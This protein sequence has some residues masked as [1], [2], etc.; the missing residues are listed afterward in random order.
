MLPPMAPSS[1]SSSR[2]PF[3]PFVIEGTPTP[4]AGGHTVCC[5]LA[6]EAGVFAAHFPGRPIV[7]GVFLLKLAVMA[8]NAVRQSE[9]PAT[10]AFD[11]VEVKNA[12]FLS[13]VEPTTV[14]EVVVEITHKPTVGQAQKIKADIVGGQ[15][16]YA[17]FV[18]VVAPT[19]DSGET[20]VPPDAPQLAEVCGL[21]PTYN[22]AATLAGVV[23]GVRARLDHVIVVDDGSDDT[24]DEILAEVCGADQAEQ[25]RRGFTVL[26]HPHNRG[27]GAALATGLGYARAEGYRYAVTVD[28]DG[29]H[30]PSDIPLLL[31]PL[32]THPDA[33]VLGSR[34]SLSHP[35]KS[36]GS[37]FANRFSNFWFAVQTF[38]RLPDT[39]CGLRVYPL[40]R[41][42]SRLRLTS[43]YEAELTLLVFP[44]WRGT[45]VVPVTVDVCYP[46][47]AERVSHFRPVRDFARISLLNTCLCFLAV[48]WG[49]PR[50]AWHALRRRRGS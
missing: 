29:Q 20:A 13:V 22:N 48:V 49:W 2:P 4:V 28:A 7:P 39:Q 9:A 25:R 47:A 46:P 26:T 41:L 24:T 15:T 37:T 3:F 45:E 8:F 50:L 33:L 43:G 38:R 12:K 44:V 32:G 19:A 10:P 30:R 34:R 18:L 16:R 6:K 35:D 17:T 42:P 1:L 21:I 40:R 27:K 11:I 5:R 31:A 23:R 14:D 36:A